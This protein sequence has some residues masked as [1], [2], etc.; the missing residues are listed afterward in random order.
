MQ[1]QIQMVSVDEQ[2]APLAYQRL[3]FVRAAD[4]REVCSLLS[5]MATR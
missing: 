4:Q 3:G 1:D 2:E 5:C